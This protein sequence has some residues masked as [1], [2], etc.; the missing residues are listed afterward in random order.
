MAVPG[1]HADLRDP[2]LADRASRRE[3]DGQRLFG[4]V[5]GAAE[6][7]GA[8]VPVD[9]RVPLAALA[10]ADVWPTRRCRP[11]L[12]GGRRRPVEILARRDQLERVG[13]L[14]L[15]TVLPNFQFVGNERPGA[16]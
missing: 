9:E 3:P 11:V 15:A 13:G 4:R 7:N 1:R 10:E 12:T 6:R 16:T 8:D 2:G 14:L 5:L